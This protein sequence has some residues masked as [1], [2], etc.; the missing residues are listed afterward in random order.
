MDKI[1]SNISE[2]EIDKLHR[3]IGLHI[4]Q[5]REE[6]SISQLEIALAIGIKSVAFYSN[7][8]NNKHNKHFNI[9]HLYKICKFLNITLSSFFSH[10]E[11]ISSSDF[12]K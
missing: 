7:C 5:L 4:K 8:E 10:T 2:Q 9:E 1:L 11:Q 12:S 6:K 3:T